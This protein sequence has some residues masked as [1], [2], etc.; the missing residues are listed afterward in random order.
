M[1]LNMEELPILKQNRP[2]RLFTFD[3]MALFSCDIKTHI[4][5]IRE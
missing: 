4:R 3:P 5:G 2:Y 1:L